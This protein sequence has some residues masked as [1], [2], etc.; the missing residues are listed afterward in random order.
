MKAHHALLAV[1]LFSLMTAGARADVFFPTN[2]TLSNGLQVVVVPNA[3][4]PVVSQMVWYKVGAADEGAGKT[5]LAHYL[6]HLMFRGTTNVPAGEF[7][8][9]IAAQ[10]GNDNAFTSR[11]YTAYFEQIEASRL[12]MIMQ[13]EA[14]RMQNLRL[15]YETAAPELR[16]IIE[17]RQQR[18]DNSPEGRFE[19]KLNAKFLP[20]HP[21]GRPVI[22]WRRDMEKLTLADAQKFYEKY[23]APNNA[24]V[25]ISGD[26]RVEEVMRLAAATYGRVPKREV[27]PR[28][29]LPVLPAPSQS[30]YSMVDAG[31]EQPEIVWRFAA[32]SYVTQKD[33]A[34][35]AHEVLSE[36]LGGGQVGML[37]RD[38]VMDAS[39][40]SA[41]NVSYDPDARGETT[42]SIDV[43]PRPE[44]SPRKL[45]KALRFALEEIAQKGIDDALV[46]AAKERLKRAAIFAREGLMM[47]G[48]SFGMAMT[49]GHNV[50]D[51]EAWPDR[52]DAVTAEQVNAALRQLASTPRQIMATL[53]PEPHVGKPVR[54]KTSSMRG[55]EA[56]V[57]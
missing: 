50:A 12:P 19:E 9:V 8:K 52:I 15:T 38:L 48:Y 29:D 32:P 2:F 46:D 41:V 26:V 44:A 3:M 23:Y 22:G 34:A 16:V 53:L 51:V 45:G 56:G 42:F 43:T 10:G 24:I 7:S 40:A 14:D 27:P 21:Y 54:A 13:M 17:E 37:Y 1:G 49:T 11:D 30:V 55:R 6:E 31:V 4:A 33:N 35:Y 36:V 57:R 25:V 47:P 20:N 39:L 5:G 28:R 18:T